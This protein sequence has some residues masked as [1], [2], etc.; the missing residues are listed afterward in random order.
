MLYG[1]TSFRIE[2]ILPPAVRFK[3][4][5]EYEHTSVVAH[6]RPVLFLIWVHKDL[7]C[8]G[9]TEQKENKQ[10]VLEPACCKYRDDNEWC[11]VKS[12]TQDA[13]R[14]LASCTAGVIPRWS[15]D[16]CYRRNKTETNHP[17]S[18]T[19]KIFDSFSSCENSIN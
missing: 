4:L 5:S 2:L 6:K 8:A 7:N 15:C 1:N 12:R 3:Y 10:R 14:S 19:H 18:V 16:L 9:D 13:D 11:H 17:R